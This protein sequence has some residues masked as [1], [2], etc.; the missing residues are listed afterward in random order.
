MAKWNIDAADD[1]FARPM[2]YRHVSTGG[3]YEILH[4]GLE[5]TDDEVIPSV[6]YRNND[7]HV[8]I[9]AK[10]RFEDGRFEQL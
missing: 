10:S 1:T 3:V 8:F 7:G 2:M 6:V 4:Y 5:V 9:Q